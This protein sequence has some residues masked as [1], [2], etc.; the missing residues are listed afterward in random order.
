MIIRI[1][2]G[3]GGFKE[4][5]ETGQKKGRDQ[6]RDTLDQR[7]PL[8]G[9]LNAF[10]IT[11]TS[12]E[13]VG[14]RYDHITLSFPEHHVSDEL[15]HRA[16]VEFQNHALAAWPEDQRHRIAFYAEAHR[17]KIL[18]YVNAETGEQV[19]RLIHI[20]IGI[21]RRDLLTGKGIEVFGY[22]GPESDNLKYIDAWQESFNAK[23]VR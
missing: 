9:D 6:H 11:T 21:G 3:E 17:P 5:L 18:S 2:G 7:I 1:G 8:F 15:L 16:V 20:H 23:T 13:G 14:R 19:D 10:E 22:L 4:Y 12:Q